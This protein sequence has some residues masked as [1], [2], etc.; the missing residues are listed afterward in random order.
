MASVDTDSSGLVGRCQGARWRWVSRT[1]LAIFFGLL[2]I[3][4]DALRDQS[5]SSNLRAI[6]I[7]ASIIVAADAW[8]SRRMGLTVD[9]Q[10]IALH[11]ACFRKRVLWAKIQNFEWRRWRRAGYEWIWIS[12]KDGRPIRIPTIQRSAGGQTR[13]FLNSLLTSEN[14][15]IKGSAEVDAM[16]MLQQAQATTQNA[17]KKHQSSGPSATLMVPP[18]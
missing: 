13:S 12:V 17:L 4:P 11:Y 10:G 15:R 14:V 1:I 16:N 5:L 7:T 9:E 3:N 18:L 2:F 6:A 8:F